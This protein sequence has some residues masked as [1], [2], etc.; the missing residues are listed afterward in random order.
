[1]GP[2]TGS[3]PLRSCDVE[4]CMSATAADCVALTDFSPPCSDVFRCCRWPTTLWP[5]GAARLLCGSTRSPFQAGLEW[6]GTENSVTWSIRRGRGTQTRGTPFFWAAPPRGL[7]RQTIPRCC[8]GFI[9]TCVLKAVHVTYQQ[10][11]S[12]DQTGPLGWTGW[13]STRWGLHFFHS[14][15]L[16]WSPESERSTASRR[17]H[18][19]PWLRLPSGSK[20]PAGIKK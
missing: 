19:W 17:P 18:P 14:T 1:M 3:S 16:A 9:K 20:H 13:G 12:R 10:W 2:F 8:T 4:C 5:C 11:M 15:G 7:T 6:L